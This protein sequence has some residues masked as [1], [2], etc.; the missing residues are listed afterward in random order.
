MQPGLKDKS[1]ENFVRK[2]REHEGQ[3][4]FM[5]ATTSVKENVLRASHLVA[6]R[7]AKAITPITIGEEL[8]LAATKDISRELLGEAGVGKITYAPLWASTVTRPIEE[9]AE[10]IETQLLERINASPWYELQVGEST[11]IDN[12]AIMLVY[13]RYLYQGECKTLTMSLLPQVISFVS[14][15][16]HQELSFSQLSLHEKITIKK[17]GRSTT[18]ILI[19]QPDIRNK[20]KYIRSFNSEWYQRKN[21]L[22]GC[23]VKNALFCFPYLLLELM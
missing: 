8:I 23:Q 13:V 1:L 15:S 12:K 19:C 10:D 22:C 17:R 21:W 16:E 3:N 14:V 9:I 5:W 2:Q 7:I 11:D 6:N 4:K 18:D 20:E